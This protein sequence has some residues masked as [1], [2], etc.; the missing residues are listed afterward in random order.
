MTHAL[1]LICIVLSL[2]L[3]LSAQSPKE[4][5]IS[6]TTEIV[7]VPVIVTDSS[8][9]AVH[10][11]KKEDFQVKENGKEQ[12]IASFEEV[13]ATRVT[14]HGNTEQ[15]GIYTN[16]LNNENPVALGI[17]VID[18]V[19]TRSMSQAWALRGALGFLD[20]WKGKGGF[21][22][23]VMVAAITR[24]GLRIIHQATSSPEV[25]EAGAKDGDSSPLPLQISK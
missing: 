25:L 6:T 15:N 1:R 16:R 23:P 2:A 19:N 22:Q 7:T 4:D 21:Q 17:L 14:I 18:F 20:K 11:L 3:L 24:Q 10:G 5:V 12:N 9:K 8:G 13:N